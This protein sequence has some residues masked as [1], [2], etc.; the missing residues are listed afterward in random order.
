MVVVYKAEDTETA[1]L[2]ALKVLSS[3]SANQPS[4]LERFRARRGRGLGS[5]H[6]NI[7]LLLR[8][9]EP[10]SSIMAMELIDGIDVESMCSA[11]RVLAPDDALQAS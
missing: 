4:R 2:V 8:V 9:R 1:E 7:V 11:E 5:R 6:D 10:G 3:E